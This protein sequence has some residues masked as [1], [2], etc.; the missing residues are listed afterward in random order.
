MRTSG[1]TGS[2]RAAEPIGTV[3]GERFLQPMT[4]T[5]LDAVMAIE[6]AAYAFP[7][8]RGNFI[9]SLA[10]GHSAWLLTDRG[11]TLLGYYVAM[12][13]VDEMHLLNIT[14]APGAQRRGHARFLIEALVDVAREHRA[15]HLWLEVRDSNAAA[16]AMYRQLGFEQMGVRKG[17]Y[18]DAF[19]RREDAVVM[20]LR[21]D[22]VS[23]EAG[24]ALA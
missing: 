12:R 22:A 15:S 16:R 7:W 3:P 18:P 19:A 5:Q 4:T 2:S 6:V 24:D 9:D 11:D 13:G 1:S 10:A 17:Y 14:V 23:S 20:S 8:S 21:I